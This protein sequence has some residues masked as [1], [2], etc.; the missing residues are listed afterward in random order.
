MRCISNIL[1]NIHKEEHHRKRKRE[2]EGEGGI[3]KEIRKG[4]IEGRKGRKKERP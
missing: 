4:R 2:R 1:R 3:E